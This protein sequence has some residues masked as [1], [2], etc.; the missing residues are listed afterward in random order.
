MR[1]VP[2]AVMSVPRP[3]NC[4][5][6]PWLAASRARLVKRQVA[7]V[8]GAVRD[9]RLNDAGVVVARPQLAERLGHAAPGLPTRARV[10]PSEIDREWYR[11]RGSVR[12]M[13]LLSIWKTPPW[14]IRNDVALRSVP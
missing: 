13:P 7:L 9:E 5:V 11:R 10:P 3:T 8:P 14:P 1:F 12:T 2:A 6:L 4:T